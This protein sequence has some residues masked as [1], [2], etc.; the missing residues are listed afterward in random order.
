MNMAC[1]LN[2]SLTMVILQFYHKQ[3]DSH[4][5]S[6]LP[7]WWQVGV[8]GHL[9]LM[10]EVRGALRGLSLEMRIFLRSNSSNNARGYRWEIGWKEANLDKFIRREF[11]GTD[12]RG[13]RS[14]EGSFLGQTL[15]DGRTVM[16]C[17][18]K[19]FL[20]LVA[21]ARLSLLR[22]DALVWGSCFLIVVHAK[23]VT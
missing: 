6:S 5:S 14:H 4:I 12:A 10:P 3:V 18:S 13:Q 20:S 22:L 11:L 1:H 2:I 23:I 17:S 19:R 15:N 16:F 7:E 21:G 9:E 8:K